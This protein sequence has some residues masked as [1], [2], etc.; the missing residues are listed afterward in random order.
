[1]YDHLD[2]EP[3]YPFGHGLSYT[4]FEYSGLKVSPDGEKVTVPPSPSPF[5]SSSSSLF[6]LK[7]TL[8]S[9]A[10]KGLR[11]FMAT[12][13]YP[14]CGL[15]GDGLNGLEGRCSDTPMKILDI[16]YT[17]GKVTYMDIYFR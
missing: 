8:F 11:L 14:E 13:Y 9:S 1:M 16:P 6:A 10:R 17:R 2:V 5:S 4:E 12:S 15:S 3:A 7:L